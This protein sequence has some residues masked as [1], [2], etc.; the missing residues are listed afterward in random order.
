MKVI[1]IGGGCLKGKKTM[2]DE[3]SIPAVISRLKN[4]HMLVARHL[5]PRPEARREFS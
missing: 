1:K 4:R 2:K 5:I 3:A